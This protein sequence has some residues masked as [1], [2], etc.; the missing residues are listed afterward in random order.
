MLIS[1]SRYLL[2][3]VAS[4]RLLL[5]IRLTSRTV[6]WIGGSLKWTVCAGLLE[7][8]RTRWKHPS[9]CPRRICWSL[10]LTY[11]ESFCPSP[12]GL[13]LSSTTY[14]AASTSAR[15][16]RGKRFVVKSWGFRRTVLFYTIFCSIS[17]FIKVFRV[18]MG[19]Y[20]IDIYEK[21]V[22]SPCHHGRECYTSINQ[23]IKEKAPSH[24]INQSIHNLLLI[25]IKSTNQAINLS[26]PW[27]FKY[28]QINQSTTSHFKISFSLKYRGL[29]VLIVFCTVLGDEETNGAVR[30]I[31]DAGEG[32]NRA[33]GLGTSMTIIPQT[34]E[35]VWLNQWYKRKSLK[36][37]DE[38]SAKNIK[39]SNRV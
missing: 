13:V 34:S 39:N 26:A 27:H 29:Q 3:V 16:P 25:S 11:A 22:R 14:A 9:G 38:P 24:S 10:N 30:W 4:G 18:E 8:L 21:Q 31:G 36:R 35:A 7:R 32:V 19:N 1:H 28:T 33:W 6:H 2:Q 12:S 15:K 37:R 5:W 17:C 23:S 20:Q